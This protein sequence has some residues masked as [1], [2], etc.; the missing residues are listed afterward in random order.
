ML[1]YIVENFLLL[2]GVA[3]CVIILAGLLAMVIGVVVMI[4]LLN[5]TWAMMNFNPEDDGDT[6][7]YTP[8]EV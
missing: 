7:D 6:P 1:T 2:L 3:I 4:G 5:H 8:I